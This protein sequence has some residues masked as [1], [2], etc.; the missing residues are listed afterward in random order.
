MRGVV[1]WSWLVTGVALWPLL[2][3]TQETIPKVNEPLLRCQSELAVVRTA[4]DHF[5]RLV[6]EQM[7][8][9]QIQATLPKKPPVE[10][11][12]GPKQP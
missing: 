6:A 8:N 9:Q 1:L 2:G 4:R 5:E 12:A 10:P 11:E 7:L 3:W